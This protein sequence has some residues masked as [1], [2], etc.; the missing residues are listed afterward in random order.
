MPFIRCVRAL[1]VTELALPTEIRDRREI[2]GA[3]S[4]CAVRAVIDVAVDALEHLR[5]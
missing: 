4:L 5:K 1:D 2:V 3:E